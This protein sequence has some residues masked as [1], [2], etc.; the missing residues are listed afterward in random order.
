[1]AKKF[2]KTLDPVTFEVLRGGFNYIPERMFFTLQRTSFTPII[3][4]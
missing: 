4:E 2:E 1:M 3:Y